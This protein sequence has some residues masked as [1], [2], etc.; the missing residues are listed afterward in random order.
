MR[1][2]LAAPILILTLAGGFINLAAADVRARIMINGGGSFLPDRDIKDAGGI[3]HPAR[4]EKGLHIGASGIID[5]HP[6]FA[7]EAG[8]RNISGEFHSRDSVLLSSGSPI[9]FN[10]Q[11]IFFNAACHTRYSG[12]GLRLF[13]T[14]GAGLRRIHPTSG[15]GADIGWSINY[16][17]GIEGR[18]SRRI[19][20]RVEIRDFFG[21]MPRFVSSQRDGGL[22]HD[23]QPSI[24]LIFHLQ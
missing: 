10:V 18:A 22:L 14:G 11:Q 16:G 6:W 8:F 15:V 1:R 4:F 2:Y 5:L 3:S 24:G 23:I 17:G 12:G 7:L 21:R 13:A 19:S 20:L 9:S